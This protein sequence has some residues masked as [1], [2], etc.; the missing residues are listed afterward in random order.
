MFYELDVGVF[1]F[2]TGGKLVCKFSQVFHRTWDLLIAYI[3]SFNNS[4][5]VKVIKKNH[6]NYQQRLI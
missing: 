6:E 3:L 4:K 1:I 2:E 5:L